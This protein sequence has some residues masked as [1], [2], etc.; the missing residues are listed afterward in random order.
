MAVLEVQG[1]TTEFRT[2]EGLI[3]PSDHVS[4]SIERGEIVGLVGE[5]GSGK[6]VTAKAVLR[7]IEPPS[8]VRSGKALFNGQDLL[9]MSDREL[10]RI[11]GR[12]ITMIF[13]DPMTS[14][15]PVLAIG[16]Q[17]SRVYRH[18]MASEVGGGARRLAA[19]AREETVKV[20]DAVRI[21]KPA[22][23]LN[24][25]PHQFSGGMR[26]RVLTAAALI[27]RPT[28]IIAD[29]PTTA[30]DV[31]VELQV[32]QLLRDLQEQFGA[33]ILFISHNLNVIARLCA[34]VLIMYGGRIVEVARTEDIFRRPLHP[35]TMAL[36]GSMPRGSKHQR[37]LQPIRGEP[38]NL[39]R[40]PQG[41]PFRPRCD[42][43]VAACAE[44][45]ALR[46]VEAGR[47]AACHRA[48]VD[49]SDRTNLGHSEGAAAT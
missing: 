16:E 23:R 30:L 11:R 35:Y 3:R 15:N 26:Q 14:L 7:L 44:P 45:Q 20:L 29:E 2:E 46:E 32:V 42:F 25:Y 37:R 33:A 5:S 48:P 22:E 28:L 4:F 40:L 27:C 43:A 8:A 12:E 10:N 1:L 9:K 34:R 18:H 17:V 38:P 19:Q 6:S 24:Q 21:P 31:T 13:Q 39:A 49:E 41:C 47:W 36:L